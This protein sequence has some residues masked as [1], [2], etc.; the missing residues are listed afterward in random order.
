MR[1]A[2]AARE[3]I[4]LAVVGTVVRY[5]CRPVFTNLYQETLLLRD[6]RTSDGEFLTDHLWMHMGAR[7]AAIEPV[8]GDVLAFTA[9]VKPYVK[10]RLVTR[11]NGRLV[12]L[13][14]TQEY[15]LR[16]PS[17]IVKLSS[18]QGDTP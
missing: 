14:A 17:R 13:R 5:G 6:V 12:Q 15:G 16:Y 1:E 18:T 9:W 8:S 2:L 7:L 4:R 3:G 10:H 11:R